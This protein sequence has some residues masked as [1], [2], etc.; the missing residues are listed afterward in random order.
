MTGPG[1]TGTSIGVIPS[2]DHRPNSG[3]REGDIDHA[4]VNEAIRYAPKTVI[5]G[6][7]TRLRLGLLM[8]DDSLPRLHAGH[9]M[10]KF[11]YG[12]IRQIPE[13]VNPPPRCPTKTC[14][15]SPP[16]RTVTH[17]LHWESSM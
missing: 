12:A 17:P 4:E 10:V 15:S 3:L 8:E 1:D 6:Q 16:A 14:P 2:Q 9:D 13:G 5:F 11:F 7:Q